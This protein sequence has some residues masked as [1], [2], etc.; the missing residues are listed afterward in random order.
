MGRANWTDG[1]GWTHF[2]PMTRSIL[3]AGFLS[4]TLLA[5]VDAQQRPDFSG[6]W[7]VSDS[8]EV[9]PSVAATGDA[10][11]RT[12]NMGSGWGS[13]LKISQRGDSLIVE[14]TVFSSYD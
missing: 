7:A 14:Y 3:L 12:G 10:S 1:R 9:R 2:V 5:L 6:T 13:P 8:A 4:A 11:F